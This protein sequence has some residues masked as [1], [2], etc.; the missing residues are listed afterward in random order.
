[1][2]LNAGLGC[3]NSQAA[4]APLRAGG[5]YNLLISEWHGHRKLGSVV[6]EGTP[7]LQVFAVLAASACKI[8]MRLAASRM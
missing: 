6:M 2:N 4:E 5:R 3:R 7:P 8:Y 1:M